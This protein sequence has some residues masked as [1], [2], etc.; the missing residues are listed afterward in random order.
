MG[1]SI[2]DLLMVK[3]FESET[4]DKKIIFFGIYGKG[5]SVKES[6]ELKELFKRKGADILIEN[7]NDIPNILN[8]TKK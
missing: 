1:D 3:K 8:N 7:V 2:E 4:N 5:E 6:E